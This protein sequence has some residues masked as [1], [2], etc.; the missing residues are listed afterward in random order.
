MIALTAY[1]LLKNKNKR[2]K[3]AIVNAN[4]RL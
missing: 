3:K 4:L 1:Y 2:W